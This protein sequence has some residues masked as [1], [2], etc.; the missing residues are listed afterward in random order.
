MHLSAFGFDGTEEDFYAHMET[1]YTGEIRNARGIR[2]FLRNLLRRAFD[3]GR[4]LGQHE[5]R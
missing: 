2:V 4:R 1:L 5:G 3:L